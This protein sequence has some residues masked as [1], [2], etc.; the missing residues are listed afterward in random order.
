[1]SLASYLSVSERAASGSSRELSGRATAGGS[2]A[3]SVVRP[4]AG[5]RLRLW[6][7]C[8]LGG[9][10][11]AGAVLGLFAWLSPA[12]PLFNPATL[13]IWP[14]SAAA[15]CLVLAVTLGLWLDHGIASHLRGLS[16][17]IASG[18]PTELGALPAAARWGELS[19]LTAQLQ[20]LLVRQRELGRGLLELEELRHRIRSLRVAVEM[21]PRG[22]RTEPLRP[23][24]GPLGPLIE[25]LN[26]HWADDEE[27]EVRS[28]EEAL[29]LR[30]ELT[31]ALADARDSTVQAE[32]GFV[33]ATAL[34]ATVRELQR[35]GG[36][37]QQELSPPA[38][39][40]ETAAGPA[41]GAAAPGM[42]AAE[43]PAAAEAQRRYREAA[44]A[45]IEELVTASRESV[46]HLAAGF[47]Q[48]HEIGEHVQVL[49]NR[50]TL[51]ALNV[52]VA[53]GSLPPD[54]EP[55]AGAAP[56]PEGL[57]RDLKSLATEVRAV[58]DRTA[59]LSRTIDREVAA[60]VERMHGL[61]ERVAARLDEAPPLS[62]AG[63][64]EPPAAEPPEAALRLLERVRQLVQDAAAKGERLSAT[65]ERASRAADR[66]LRRLEEESVVL[67]RLARRF[68]AS[69]DDLHEE[70]GPA[71]DET[72]PGDVRLLGPDEPKPAAGG[73]SSGAGTGDQRQGDW[74]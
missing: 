50:A 18:D 13:G 39:V 51:I 72:P 33:E 53:R 40:A 71:A 45:A 49:A 36:E 7:A 29:G 61:R 24:E 44:A 14:W 8:L 57:S 12:D 30:R 28:R 11:G 20:S 70:A 4:G 35:L 1:M 64:G 56:R 16:R 31:L 10:A 2:A 73:P 41:P 23:L 60:A 9:F 67:E 47:S 65:G 54:A 25:V 22:Q 59:E 42:G 27:V 38:S 58:T 3:K 66:L 6:V 63:A 74:P 48:V 55:G 34:L 5:L 52:A 62:E 19:L 32:R 26:R 15:F 21:R 68:G 17:A 69:E 43:A 37:L 46:E